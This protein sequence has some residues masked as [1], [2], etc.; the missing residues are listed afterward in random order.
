MYFT[1]M[2]LNPTRRGT[3]DL[4]A[5]PQRMHAAVLAGFLP[6]VADRDRILWR[7]D[8]PERHRLDLHVVSREE[9]SCEGLADQA[10][11]PS[12][13]T[14]RSAPY[15]PLLDSLEA[16]QRWVF[17]LRANPV[18]S[19]RAEGRDR[20]QRVPVAGEARRM[21]WLLRQGSAHGFT[22]PGGAHERPNARVSEDRTEQFRRRTGTGTVTLKTVTFEGLLQVTDPA[23]LREALVSGIGPAKGYGCGLITLARPT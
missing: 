13:P 7:L 8:N 19:V 16:G 15:T 11:W 18:R 14:W 9:P 21:E 3:R 6:D 5:S 17:R 22:V 12:Q 23:A 2:P 10:G 4:V 20:G 1:H